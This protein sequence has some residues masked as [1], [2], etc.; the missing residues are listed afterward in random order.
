MRARQVAVA[1]NAGRRRRRRLT[2]VLALVC[3]V[4][5]SL[6]GLRSSLVD[7]D[8]VQV[9][10]AERTPDR[11][12]RAASGIFT[13]DTMV[14]ADLD[15]G[16]VA[17]A[18]LPWVDEVRITRLWPGTVRIVVTERVPVVAVAVGDG[19]ARI[20]ARGRVLDQ[21]ST[22]P[23]LIALQGRRKV[24][25]G[26]VLASW[27]RDLADLIDR[28]PD[29]LAAQVEGVGRDERG[30]VLDLTGGWTVLVGEAGALPA[31]SDAVAAVRTAA[32]PGDGCTID[33]RVP[34]APVL[35]PGGRCA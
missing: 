5:W 20:D 11:A 34:S 9:D 32:D 7:V 2:A 8:R 24:A 33:V 17:V 27:D 29:A 25:P 4:V 23:A 16:T 22:R 18:A 28:L 13:G 31:Q 21:A 35:T 12:I 1:R 19:W 30:V 3:V 14:G 15:G 26:D 10:G 6:V